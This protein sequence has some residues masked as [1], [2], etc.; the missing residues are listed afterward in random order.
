MDEDGIFVLCHVMLGC[1]MKR[2]ILTHLPLDKMVGQNG[3]HFAHDIFNRIFINE[4][5]CI[6]N[7][8]SL[9]FVPKDPIHN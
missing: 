2:M 4:K 1:D 8:I 9:K 6:L 5:F 7:R 3:R